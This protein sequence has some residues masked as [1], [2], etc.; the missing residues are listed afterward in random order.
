MLKEQ[1]EQGA[2]LNR[3]SRLLRDLNTHNTTAAISIFQLPPDAIDIC[4]GGEEWEK[5]GGGTPAYFETEEPP[6]CVG[7]HKLGNM[8]HTKDYLVG[9]Q[10]WIRVDDAMLITSDG[11]LS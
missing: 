7:P 10:F 4:K 6:Y 2:V 3:I 5:S 1:K 11:L 8:E 9:V